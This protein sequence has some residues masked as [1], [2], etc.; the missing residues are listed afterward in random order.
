MFLVIGFKV[1]PK[2][3]KVISLVYNS[4]AG[5]S[6]LLSNATTQLF[7]NLYYYPTTTTL[8]SVFTNPTF[9]FLY[10][11]K[12]GGKLSSLELFPGKGIQYARSAGSCAKLLKLDWVTHTALLK[13]PSGVRKLFSIYSFTNLGASSRSD[14][15]FLKTT[16]SGFYRNL[17]ISVCVRGIAQNPVDHPHGGRTKSIKYPRTP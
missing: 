15:Q 6:F 3:H 1:L 8:A 17:G 4:Y 16:K 11:L 5:L 7:S 10:Q 13:L 2:S 12:G 14:K 9:A